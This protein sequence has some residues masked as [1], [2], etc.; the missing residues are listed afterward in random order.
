MASNIMQNLAKILSSRYGKDVR[1]AIHDSIHDC[2][3]DGKAGSTDLIAREQ[4]ANLVSENNP[5]EGNSE[6]QDIRVGHDGTTYTSAGESVRQQVGSLSEDKQNKFVNY[7]NKNDEDCLVGYMFNSDGTLKEYE[8]TFVT[9]YIPCKLNDQIRIIH[10]GEII[11][12]NYVYCTF[13]NANKEIAYCKAIKGDYLLVPE[14]CDYVR[15]CIRNR[16]LDNTM[17][18]INDKEL[19]QKYYPYGKII[20]VVFDSKS[21]I[22]KLQEE[23]SNMTDNNYSGMKGVAFGTSLTYRAETTGG[24][25]QYLPQLMKCEIENQGVGSSFFYYNVQNEYNILY[26]IKNYTKFDEKDFV[27]IEGCVNDWQHEKELGTYKDQTEDSVCGCLYNMFKHIYIE[28]PNIMIFVVLDHYGRKYGSQDLSP[29]SIRGEYTQYEYYEEVFKCC[30]YNGIPCL[31][32]YAKSY[33]GGFGEQ[34]LMD[35]IHCNDLGARQSANTIFSFINSFLPK[36]VPQD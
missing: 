19:Y 2:Y 1:Q 21:N 8:I 36:E 26:N 9:G 11:S 31:K 6:L 3:E 10:D 35:Y 7:F 16:Y 28:N 25:L 4:I 5:T 17:I 30:E 24:Y 15:I 27:I 32:E 18:T 34:Y 13:Y 23:V 12:F 20:D 22:E 14:P 33:F 29:S